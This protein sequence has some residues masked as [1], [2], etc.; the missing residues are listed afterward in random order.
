[1]GSHRGTQW[2]LLSLPNVEIQN[3]WSY[4]IQRWSYEIQNKWSYEIQNKW[5]HEIQN[6]WSY[7]I[8][9]K[10]SFEIQNYYIILYEPKNAKIVTYT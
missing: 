7:E 8:Q 2:H 3:K 4:E 10:W 9:N 1:L 5:S 6:K